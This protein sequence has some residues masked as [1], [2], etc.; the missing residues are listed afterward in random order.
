MVLCSF[1]TASLTQSF[2]SGTYALKIKFTSIYSFLHTYE[3]IYLLKW[4]Y[5]GLFRPVGFLAFQQLSLNICHQ[6][7]AR[8]NSA[9][10]ITIPKFLI[11]QARSQVFPTIVFDFFEGCCAEFSHSSW[12][13]S[14]PTLTKESSKS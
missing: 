11:E 13:N 6:I 3:S 7:V 14:I 2:N 8:Q 4:Y 10:N 12:D 5:F 9:W 1:W